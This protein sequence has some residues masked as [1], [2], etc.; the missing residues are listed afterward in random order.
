MSI[1]SDLTVEDLR[2]LVAFADARG[3]SAGAKLLGVSQPA[4]SKRMDT[5]RALKPPV[6]HKQGARDV[7]TDRGV[8]AAASA[9]AILRQI[10]D[11]RA[12]LKARQDSPTAL[13]L[14]AGSVAIGWYLAPAIARL[15]A[16]I[17]DLQI[18]TRVLRGKQR[19]E[20]VADGEL[21]MAIVSHDRLQIDV[22]AHGQSLAIMP[23]ATQPLCAVA[24]AGTT[25][26]GDMEKVLKGQ[27]VPLSLLAHWDLV[28]LDRN[29]G[30]R[31][32]L[33]RQSAGSERPLRFVAETGGWAGA[34]EYARHGLGVA[35]LPVT[36]LAER[37]FS[38]F[39][40]RRLVADAALQHSLIYRR[41]DV[42]EIITQTAETI[43]QVA[44]QF[45]IETRRRWERVL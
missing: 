20:G 43:Q 4:F 44:Q 17:P 2:Y 21:D 42:R 22:L 1:L 5:W 45:E 38:D 14:A 23:L 40:V 10:D 6:V 30:V 3:V 15:A 25:A 31:R 35:I 16:Q 26:A 39:V 19:I 7:L 36:F 18:H 29:S 13:Y 9:R 32:F 33:E 28:G 37:D 41:E 12:F 34:K 27:E 8:Q 11:L 24:K